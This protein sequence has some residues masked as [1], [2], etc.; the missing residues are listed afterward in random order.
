MMKLIKKILFEIFRW[1]FVTLFWLSGWRINRETIEDD[2][3]I[4]TGS[5]HT[6]N[7]D[8]PVFLLAALTLRRKIY[9]TVKKELMAFPPAGWFIRFVGGIPIDRS[10]SHNLVDQMV[11]RLNE[12]DKMVLLFTPDGTRSYRPNWKTGFYWTAYKAGLPIM[13]GIPNYP[14]KKIYLHDPFIPSGD[15]EKDFEMIREVQEKYGVGL[16][17]ENT[18]PVVLRPKDSQSGEAEEASEAIQQLS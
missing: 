9:V 18:N 12:A 3:I 17:P 11:E 4:L 7:W 5:P 16:Y 2:K 13:L 10:S 1:P 15:I 8:Y 14:E 6:S